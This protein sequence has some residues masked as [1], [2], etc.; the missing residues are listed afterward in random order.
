ML[1]LNVWTDF[2][3]LWKILYDCIYFLLL[4]NLQFLHYSENTWSS[5]VASDT[6]HNNTGQQ[7]VTFFVPQ[8]SVDELNSN[9]YAEF[10]YVHR[11]FLS[12]KV[13][14]IEEFK[15]AK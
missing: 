3:V 15:C 14:K 7:N 11:F 5:S 9:F 13:S 12:D 6:K 10:R 4:T 2:Y 8:T 1:L